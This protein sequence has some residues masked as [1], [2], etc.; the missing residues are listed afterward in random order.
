VASG[1]VLVG[2][3]SAAALHLLRPSPPSTG[4]VSRWDG[5]HGE[6]H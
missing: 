6:K 4:D 2:S 5:T 1:F 3:R